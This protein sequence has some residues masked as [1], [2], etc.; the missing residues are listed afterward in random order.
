MRRPII[1]G[2]WK[3]NMTPSQTRRLIAELKPLISDEDC[4][5]VIC[6]PSC[7]LQAAAEALE[8]SS[9]RLG[10]QNVHWEKSGA[11][12]GEVSTDMLKELNVEFVIVGHSERRQ[13]FAETDITVNKRARAAIAAGLTP[14]ICVGESL[15]ERESGKTESVVSLQTEKALEGMTKQEAAHIVLAYEPIWA[16]GTGRTATSDQANETIAVIREQVRRLYGSAADDVRIQYGGSMKPGNAAE[17]MAMSEIDGGL[18]GGASL[19]A[20]DFAAI[21]HYNK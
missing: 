10:A 1:V 21:V 11:F 20:S 7:C 16:I 6:P 12:T 15:A 18:I 5:V 3:M 13:Y 19:K 2:N 4:D 17:L 14:I 9:I 8:G